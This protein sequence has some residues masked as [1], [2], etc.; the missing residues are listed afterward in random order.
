MDIAFSDFEKESFAVL[1]LILEYWQ[2]HYLN[3]SIVAEAL[4]NHDLASVS[5][6]KSTKS[7]KHSESENNGSDSD[8]MLLNPANTLP[9]NENAPLQETSEPVS[10]SIETALPEVEQANGSTSEN[11]AT[12]SAIEQI[13]QI[14]E[15]SAEETLSPKPEIIDTAIPPVDPSP[16]AEMPTMLAE[17]TQEIPS[18][19]EVVSVSFAPKAEEV[20]YNPAPVEEQKE[21]ESDE[22]PEAPKIYETRPDTPE[23]PEVEP[24]PVHEPEPIGKIRNPQFKYGKMAN[25]RTKQNGAWNFHT[26]NRTSDPDIVKF[27]TFFYRPTSL[28]PIPRATACVWFTLKK[29]ENEVWD[30]EYRF[31]HQYQVH[32]VQLHSSAAYNGLNFD[33]EF[34]LKMYGEELASPLKRLSY[35]IETKINA[36]EFAKSKGLFNLSNDFSPYQPAKPSDSSNAVVV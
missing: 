3:E 24:I 12:E 34:K 26:L 19:E 28:K 18:D 27:Q 32:K 17:P 25:A 16:P 7:D 8:L 15:I 6:P 5:N 35:I 14:S 4:D 21:V 9:S 36:G 2:K 10:Q 11:I 31:E 30:V 33:D 23:H 22:E 1:T 29:R 13:E 20:K